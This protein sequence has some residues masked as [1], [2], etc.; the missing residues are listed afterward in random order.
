MNMR[1]KWDTVEVL[2]HSR[3]DWL[4]KIQLIKGNLALNNVEKVHAII[5]DIVQQS[6]N[7]SN[8]SNL[9][10]NNFASYLLTVNWEGK[11]FVVEFEVFNSG[12]HLSKYDEMLTEWFTQFFLTLEDVVCEAE[13]NNIMLSFQLLNDEQSISVD[14]SG[15][16]NDVKK[17]HS[18]LHNQ[19]EC[20]MSITDINI[21]EEELVF[22]LRLNEVK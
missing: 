14:F 5:E 15:K 10:A 12:V 20:S 7:E 16:V 18:F 21:R 6:T 13:E 22:T 17:V 1:K 8:L 11:P 4:N 2:S 19:P 9:H 3:H